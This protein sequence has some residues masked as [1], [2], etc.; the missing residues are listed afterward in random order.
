M[1]LVNCLIG[2]QRAEENL[3]GQQ[4][5]CYQRKHDVSF[6]A[7]EIVLGLVLQQQIAPQEGSSGRTS[8]MA[9]VMSRLGTGL[10][11]SPPE[12]PGHNLCRRVSDWPDQAI[13]QALLCAFGHLVLSTWSAPDGFPKGQL[14]VSARRV[15]S[16]SPGTARLPTP[17]TRNRRSSGERRLLFDAWLSQI[18]Q[19]DWRT[20]TLGVWLIRLASNDLPGTVC[21]RRTRGC[22]G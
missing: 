3:P 7:R 22:L 4:R 18:I 13:Q 16:S 2:L 5:L 21:E 1:L 14:E 20:G 11:P 8:K 6:F 12:R 17:P 10:M 19:S 9:T 15:V